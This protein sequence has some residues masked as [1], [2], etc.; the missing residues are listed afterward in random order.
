MDSGLE[1][2]TLRIFECPSAVDE[3]ANY[4]EGTA[5]QSITSYEVPRP[6]RGTCDAV[7]LTNRR[8]K[9]E[10]EEIA[11]VYAVIP[12][13]DIMTMRGIA[14]RIDIKRHHFPADSFE[15]SA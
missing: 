4:L 10:I 5:Y 14:L 13:H 9:H 11:R 8:S 12:R 1:Q 3:I 15:G 6:A 7:V 2:A